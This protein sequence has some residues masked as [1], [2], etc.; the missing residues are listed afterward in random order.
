MPPIP[1]EIKSD[2]ELIVH[3]RGTARFTMLLRAALH[4]FDLGIWDAAGAE[5]S[6]YP[7]EVTFGP[8]TVFAGRARD[9]Y[10]RARHDVAASWLASGETEVFIK[11]G[12]DDLWFFFIAGPDNRP[13]ELV[14]VPGA[15]PYTPTPWI[16]YTDGGRRLAFLYEEHPDAVKRIRALP[17]AV[18]GLGPLPSAK[19]EAA[20]ALASARGAGEAPFE[21]LMARQW[22]QGEE[23]SYA[24]AFA[25]DAL[26][27][28]GHNSPESVERLLGM[29]F[30]ETLETLDV[31]ALSAMRS[32]AQD[33]RLQDF[34]DHPTL[35]G[36]VTDEHTDIITLMSGNAVQ[37]AGYE[38]E[39]LDADRVVTA[40]RTVDLPLQDGVPFSVI[41]PG[42]TG[43]AAKAERT[44]EIL[45]DAVTL[46]E[47]FMDIPYPQPYVI[48]MVADLTAAAG[49]GGGSGTIS[50]DPPYHDNEGILSHEAA[51]T[52]WPFSPRWIAEGA[53]TFMDLYYESTRAGRPLPAPRECDSFDNIG[54]LEAAEVP[55]DHPCNYSL[56]SGLF[57]DLY[58]AMGHDPFRE[59][60]GRLYTWLDEY[61]LFA[62]CG[63]SE[64]KGECYVRAAFVDYMPEHASVTEGIINR[65]FHGVP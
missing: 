25:I 32:L 52:Y 26:V 18:D 23:V 55:S 16:G 19:H 24:E 15:P 41:W 59:A 14:L 65:H 9:Q 13:R 36:G 57:L 20:Y 61:A 40:R 1:V 45:I 37:R 46:F 6:M 38:V 56:G 44:L 12:P 2:G 35:A 50:V 51:H 3:G 22:V 33:G 8:V 27:G 7:A 31:R 64:G 34:L 62:R 21:Q 39:L 30:L 11:A 49:E 4:R 29:P 53:A 10:R 17:W 60:F 42:G 63:R 28:I 54:Q 47:R 5:Q 43:T 48:V 58:D